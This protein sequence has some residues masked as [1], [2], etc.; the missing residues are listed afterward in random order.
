MKSNIIRSMLIMM[1]F[2]VSGHS[3]LTAFDWVN[4]GLSLASQNKTEEAIIC[5][6]IAIELDPNCTIAWGNKADALDKL[7]KYS[8]A[9][10][11]YG[12]FIRLDPT[13][14]MMWNNL[15]LNLQKQGY[16][17]AAIKCYD[18]ALRL[19]PNNEYA[20]ENKNNAF[21]TL[22]ESND[23]IDAYRNLDSTYLGRI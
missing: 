3:Q 9:L 7:G 16:D 8:E 11:C 20:F 17:T 4:E 1:L 15:G 2:V 18:E 14:S 19:D 5:Y 6:D 12:N 13:V 23:A 22:N 10:K 21:V